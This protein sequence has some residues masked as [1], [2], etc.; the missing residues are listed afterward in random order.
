MSY[1]PSCYY[2]SS[3][4]SIID[5]F[6][7]DGIYSYKDLC[8]SD[9]ELITSECIKLLGEE[10]YCFLVESD[11]LSKVMSHFRKHLVSGNN[12]EI[13]DMVDAM[14]QCATSY[15]GDVMNDLFKQRTSHIEESIHYENGFF[16]YMD[17]SS[18]EIEWRKSA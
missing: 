13:I 3:L 14:K 11:Q 17:K 18:G 15:F 1:I 4:L 5:S 7:E 16:K 10:A 8:E 2:N 9:K 12:D 6:I